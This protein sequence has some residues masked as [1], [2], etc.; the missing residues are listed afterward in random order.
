MGNIS[1]FDPKAKSLLAANQFFRTNELLY[2]LL[3]GWVA[4]QFIRF[5]PR[6]KKV[7]SIARHISEEH[8]GLLAKWLVQFR[9]NL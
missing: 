5:I 7:T 9:H 2:E 3:R 8:P 4:S 1:V 6:K